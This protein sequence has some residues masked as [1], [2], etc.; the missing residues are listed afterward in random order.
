MTNRGRYGKYGETR[1]LNRL[2]QGGKRIFFPTMKSPPGM[3]T[4]EMRIGKDQ[5]GKSRIRVRRARHRERRFIT[6][7]SRE[8]FSLYGP[9]EETVTHWFDSGRAM[10][11]VAL[12]RGKPVGFVMSGP[13]SVEEGPVERFEILA[14][15]VR[16]ENRRR[17]IGEALLEKTEKEARRLHIPRVYL[18]TAAEN[19]PAQ[20]LFLK[21]GFRPLSRKKNFYPKGQDALTFVKD[22]IGR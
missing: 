13:L 21:H 16:P 5:A 2:R 17:G 3:G 10:A 1:R 22:L 8:A 7:L 11:F 12:L 18:H 4:E 15:A 20:E 9:Y 14:I 6:E 19:I